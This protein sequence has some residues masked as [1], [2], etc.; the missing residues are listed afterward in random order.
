MK[1][2]ILAV[3][4]L[5]TVSFMGASV[6]EYDTGPDQVKELVSINY[7]VISVAVETVNLQTAQ[8]EYKLE[9]A[10]EVVNTSTATI[11]TAYFSRGYLGLLKHNNIVNKARAELEPAAQTRSYNYTDLISR[12]QATVEPI[13]WSTSYSYLAIQSLKRKHTNSSGGMP[14]M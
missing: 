1:N 4:L 3:L 2:V 5:C 13:P 10:A 14:R 9:G 6:P 7:D 8:T 11:S 12:T